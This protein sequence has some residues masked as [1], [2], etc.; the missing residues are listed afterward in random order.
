MIMIRVNVLSFAFGLGHKMHRNMTQVRPF[1]GTKVTPSSSRGMFI[2]VDNY[3]WKKGNTGAAGAG[4]V[5]EP[6]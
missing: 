4:F 3:Q 1:E 5:L 6:W 2:G